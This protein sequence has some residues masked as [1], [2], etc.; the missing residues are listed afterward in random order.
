MIF[1][2]FST[3][4]IDALADRLARDLARRVPPASIGASDKKA[5]SQQGKSREALLRQVR[6]FS[7]KHRLNIFKKARLANRFKWA[8]LD[9]G[10]PK[11]FVDAMAFELAAV[12]AATRKNPA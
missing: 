2:W 6:E 8:L 10:Y 12:M 11:E 9:A 4:E 3:T 1:E 5:E 7:G